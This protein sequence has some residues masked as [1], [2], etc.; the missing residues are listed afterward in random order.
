M[1]FSMF[2]K[3]QKTQ[4][5]IDIP[6]KPLRFVFYIAMQ[7]KLLAVS[8]FTFV[9]L[10]QLSSV[11][12]PLILKQI[13]DR[14]SQN[15][16]ND[17]LFWIILFPVCMFSMFFFYRV[18]G[19]IGT[20]W[21]V[22]SEIVS[23]K[24]LFDYLMS[25]SQT[26][27]N[28]RFAGS[29]TNK[30][31]HASD[32]TFRILEATL[33]GHCGAMISLVMA[34]IFI[35]YTNVWVGIVYITL[36][37]ILLPTNFYI[38]RY[39]RPF[40][41]A[42]S[43]LRTKFR[44]HAVD[45]VT[46]I[47]AVRQFSRRSDEYTNM[48]NR[49]EELFSADVRQ[50]RLGEWSL[51]FNNVVIVSSVAL[52]LGIMYKLWSAGEVSSGDFVLVLTLILQLSSTLVFIGTAMNQFIREYGE[53]EEGLD[54]ILHPYE[55]TDHS[56]AHELQIEKGGIIWSDVTFKYEEN[57]VFDNF[58]LTIKPGQRIGLV[59]SSGAGKTTFVSLLL[60][61]HDL[62]FGAITIDGQNI[63]EVTQDSLREHIAVVPQEPMLFHRTI[64]ENIMYGKSD[65]TE[66][67]VI[68]V[69]KKAH[70]HEFI[71]MLPKGYDTLVGERGIKLS[72]GQKQ[73]IAIARAMIKNAP[74]LVLDEATSALDSESEVA[75][76]GALHE[77]M[78]GKT[79]IAVAHRLSTLR[80][81]DRIIVLEDGK[82]IED[83]THA[84]LTKN[85]GLYARLWEHQAGGFLKD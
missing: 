7:N 52:M 62:D 67:E 26:Y 21:L 57:T 64:R 72:G 74:I 75:I 60:R 48:S 18:S 8:A 19:R 53:V 36:V 42:Y 77:L 78:V 14:T 65:A 24:I 12:L 44:G 1:P 22:R 85:K 28:N 33:L 56:G 79:V 54:E 69:A 49:A 9:V 71:I 3:I 31:S 16:T 39:R 41:V 38:V 20:V 35:T 47:G 51:V 32:G 45:I 27:F 68:A 80:E 2:Q 76:Q 66:D 82:I 37:L 58:N 83:G 84:K 81:M 61:Q 23:Y 34:G 73:R 11:S 4:H 30:V 43:S 15:Q 25:H 40:V 50:M 70:A 10:G 63:R 5:N 59:G 46:N 6:K 17:L 29:I 13:I 55:I